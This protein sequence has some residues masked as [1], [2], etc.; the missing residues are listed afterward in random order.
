[1]FCRMDADAN[2]KDTEI[3]VVTSNNNR[4]IDSCSLV[5]SSKNIGHHIR[6]GNDTEVAI[7]IARK[8]LEKARYEL[9]AYFRENKNWPPPKILPAPGAFHS[10]L[11]TLLIS[12]GLAWF[13]MITGPWDHA[14][15]WFTAGANNAEAV[16]DSGQWYRVI[17]SL[18]LHADFSHMAG[19]CLI[20]AFLIF[21]F[22]QTNGPGLGS[23]A[24]IISSAAGNYI[25][26]I[27][28]GSGH[29][30]VGF[31][32]AVFS[33]IGMLS[34]NRLIEQ[35]EPVGI[36]MFVPFMAGAALLAMLGSSG[37]HT[38]LG[39]H[40]FG[41]IAGLAAGLILTSAP[42]QTLRKSSFFQVCCLIST[43]ALL[44]FSW[45]KALT[46]QINFAFP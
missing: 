33:L 35:K 19:N 46:I 31:S 12:G 2:Q 38:D 28:H 25:N 8:D 3:V 42:V 9:D 44:L 15:I 20:G 6:S 4:V 36:R 41:L 18:T 10:L 7:S 27:L 29:L 16:I 24:I 26:D 32:T 17:T 34:M 45:S 43:F 21:F 23:L 39:S 11:P 22:L 1:M 40:L 14:S 30:S 37:E 5:L 13:F